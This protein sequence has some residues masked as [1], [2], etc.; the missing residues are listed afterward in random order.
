M[1][2]IYDPIEA[3]ALESVFVKFVESGIEDSLSRVFGRPVGG[4]SHY[5]TNTDQ[6]VCRQV[7]FFFSRFSNLRRATPLAD[8]YHARP[9]SI[10]RPLVY[11]KNNLSTLADNRLC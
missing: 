8:L 2:T 9:F 7:Q 10:N 4:Y 5:S 3:A 1:R 11:S 6:S